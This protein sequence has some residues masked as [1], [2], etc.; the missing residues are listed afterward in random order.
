M[1]ET[2]ALQ[3]FPIKGHGESGTRRVTPIFRHL[4]TEESVDNRFNAFS[5]L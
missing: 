3:D 4:S 5:R 1:T 2:P